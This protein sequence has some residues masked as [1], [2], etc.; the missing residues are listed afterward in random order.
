M[1]RPTGPLPAATAA[2]PPAPTAVPAGG[3]EPAFQRLLERLQRLA[4]EQ[5]RTAP[6]ADADQ[7]RQALRAAD[8]GF[9]TAMDL[10]QRLE[11]AFLAQRP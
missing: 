8:E 4:A 11:S 6:A 3:E 1:L 10:R 7:L 9:V 2:L 5:Q